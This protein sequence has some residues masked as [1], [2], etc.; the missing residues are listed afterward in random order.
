MAS[1]GV[2][3]AVGMA[4]PAAAAEPA[5]C[6]GAL[7]LTDNDGAGGRVL[8]LGLDGTIGTA[9]LYDPTTGATGNP[10]QLGIGAGGTRIINSDRTS[11]RIVN[12]V[13][14]TDQLTDVAAPA[15]VGLGIA[16]AINPANG[17]YY[18]GGYSGGN[19][20]LHSYDPI[21]NTTTA[22][23]V[24]TIGVPNPPASGTNG[25]ITF[26][27]AG[28]LYF[29]ASSGTEFALYSFAGP[30][31]TNGTA[32][33][34]AGASGLTNPVNGIAFGSDGFLYLGQSNQVSQVNPI[35]GALTG[36][37][38]A[39]T[40]VNS[41]DLASCAE[42]PSSLTVKKDVAGRRAASDQ[43]SVTATRPAEDGTTSFPVGTTTGTDTGLQNAAAEVAGPAI[44]FPGRTYTI[45]ETASGTT[46]L[47]AYTSAWECRNQAGTLIEQGTGSSG[48]FTAPTSGGVAITCT[49]TNTPVLP[50]LALDKSV[51]PTRFTVAG[52]TLTYTF[53]VTNSGNAALSD[54]ALEDPMPGL[55]T[56]T[57][58]PVALGDTLPAGDVTTCTATYE[59][60]AADITAG[61]DKTNTATVTGTPPS[62]T[63]LPPVTSPPSTATAE[64]VELP[65][66]NDDAANTPFDTPV[67]LPALT[68]DTP[69]RT[70]PLVPGATVLT[71]PDATNGGKTLVTPEGTWQV[72]PNGTVTFTPAPGYVGT[73]P[74]VEYRITDG[75]GSTDTANLVVTVRPGPTA[76]PNTDTTPQDIDVTVDPLP[77]DTPG[78]MA[79]GSTGS[80][81]ETS[82]VFPAGPNPGTVSNG[83]KTLTVPGEGIYT[84]DAVSGEVTFDPEPQFTGVA[85]A[86]TYEVTDSHGNPAR[87]TITIT[88]TPIVPVANDDTAITPFNTPVTLPAVTD[89]D[90]GDPSAPLVP[91]ATVLT[92]PDATN[93]GKTLVTPEGTWQVNANGT[94]TFTP[95]DGYTGL[96]PT[97]EYRI[98]DENGTTDVALLS[99]QVGAG[100]LADPNVD[101]TP[102]NVDVT[103]DVVEDDTPGS[104]ETFDRTSVVFPAG[105]NP[106]TV[107]NVGRTLTVPGEGVYTIDP[108]TGDVT[109]DP[110]P[111]FTGQATSV[112]YT[113]TDTA[114]NDATS[115]LT[116]TVV[117]I[118][119]VA[120]DDTASTPFNT[121][122]TLS[123]MGDDAAGAPSAPLVP[124]AT[125]LTSPDAT[126]GGKTLVTPQGTWQVDPAGSVTFT[127]APGY[128]GTTPAVEYEITDE[129]GTTDR[130]LLTVTVRPGPSAQP[131]TGATPHDTPITVP[132]LPNDTPGQRADGTPGSWDPAS[133]LFT[134]PNATHGGRTLTVPGE[135]VY[136][137]DPAT[138]AVTFDPEPGF[139]GQA[140]PVGYQVT[141]R[142]GSTVRSTLTITVAPAAPPQ[143]PAEDDYDLVLVKRAVGG[144]Q[145]KV[146]GSVRYKLTVRN[147]GADAA[148]GP[149]TLT[150]PLPA[151]LE[152][153]S[154]K[155][156]GWTCKTH[157]ARDTA[158]C[159]LRKDLGAGKKAAPVFVVAKATRAG[160]GRVVNVANVRVAGE[161]VRSNNKGRAS[162]TVVPA[163]L[164]STGF[165]L[166]PPGV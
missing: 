27:P 90:E 161:S 36:V 137:I 111:Q 19:L 135:G 91:G 164:P 95:A 78:L 55:S 151:G 98:T 69:G 157:T 136:T 52:Q 153:L 53:E 13:P 64:F 54:L 107:S 3:G 127:P 30:T 109:F 2:I 16:G 97:V 24:A 108:V 66:A 124:G 156:K 85:T 57:C 10:N 17:L 145:A 11:N 94:V 77:N 165:R 146:G 87:S 120:N 46:D 31:P 93:G 1:T 128:I 144:T 131:D 138:G 67:T 9:S 140:A 86:V 18:Y 65:V 114:G 8:R 133:V 15:T 158:S 4:P 99:V 150:D 39:L 118:V 50:E 92:S 35:T 134:S 71:S 40:G 38:L 49:F 32:T 73:T 33:R 103:V 148:P 89:D 155:G 21:A 56:P 83:G 75:D 117:P 142:N 51:S 63:G 141:D 147:T 102:Q 44:I 143:P 112:T 79:D 160:L 5:D 149:I 159:V 80:W 29:V 43:F 96:T 88:V 20:V 82:V 152:L 45:T 23:P 61:A 48:E 121:P 14:A 113:V 47:N 6:V 22:S 104:G 42:A 129:N 100:P 163:Q 7:Y 105:P 26:D 154:A 81:D 106:G 166:T 72:N 130:A 125:V 41:T 101:Q 116:I 84:V 162:I 62:G 68:D 25:D 60:T 76:S 122:V 58:A 123:A 74:P 139:S 110:E 132:L 115:T 119:P 34:L 70:S 59:V 126:N 12:Y 37:D 28:N